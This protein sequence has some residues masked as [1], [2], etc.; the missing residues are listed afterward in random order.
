MQKFTEIQKI[1]LFYFILCFVLFPLLFYSYYRT[2]KS[3]GDGFVGGAILSC[4]LWVRY[5]RNMYLD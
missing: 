5:G 2:N 4:V 3:L 1:L